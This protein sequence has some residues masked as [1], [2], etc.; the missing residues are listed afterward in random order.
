VRSSSSRLTAPAALANDAVPRVA[1]RAAAPVDRAAFLQWFEALHGAND[2]FVWAAIFVVGP[3]GAELLYRSGEVAGLDEA[4]MRLAQ[5]A[6]QQARLKIAPLSG[7]GPVMQTAMAAPL[8]RPGAAAVCVAVLDRKLADST[9]AAPLFEAAAGQLA[10]APVRPPASLPPVATDAADAGASFSAADCLALLAHAPDQLPEALF[11]RFTA[12]LHP[13]AAVLTVV[14]GSWIAV[15]RSSQR[16]DFLPH[17]SRAG[18]ARR[19]A[20]LGAARAGEAVTA[21]WPFAGTQEAALDLQLLAQQEHLAGA[22]AVHLPNPGGGDFVYYA[23]YSRRD[24]LVGD[25][26]LAQL[27]ERIAALAP[28][29][30][31][32]RSQRRE[33]SLAERL[34]GWLDPRSLRTWLV[35]GAIVAAV[36]LALPAPYNVVGEMTLRASQQQAVVAPRDGYL[37]E[38]SVRAGDMVAAG[39]V[40]AEFDTRELSLRR[41]RVVAQIGQAEARRLNAIAAFETAAVQIANAEIDALVAERDLVD[42]LLDQSRI[43]AGT[44]AIVVTGDMRDRVGSAM[45]QGEPMFKL[46]PTADLVAAIDIPQRD[47][48]EVQPGQRG[49]LQLTALPFDT[50]SLTVERI[51]VGADGE[52]GGSLFTAIAAIE[53]WHDAFRP[54]MQ[55][56]AHI[57]VGEGPRA[58]VLTRDFVYWLR[59]QVWRWVP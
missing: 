17:G 32:Q 48:T 42:L 18:H 29:L 54:G 26:D 59:M 49:A 45:R 11:A 21:S 36:W 40:I 25:N 13:T 24:D 51:S 43:V 58:W 7:R 8:P 38:A 31:Q 1:G 4:L 20:I 33:I 28:V 30:A 55:G 6:H 15:R 19:T 50:F 12:A 37:L 35:A 53:G 14:R 56:V 52:S 5:Q 22:V 39:D 2:S 10:A 57:E 34:P 46:A 23:E 3:D 16:A 47:L 9:R 44:D 27:A 41:S